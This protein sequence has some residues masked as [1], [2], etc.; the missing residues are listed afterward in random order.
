MLG[1]AIAYADPERA[2]VLHQE[3]PRR[4]AD[5]EPVDDVESGPGTPETTPPVAI[6]HGRLVRLP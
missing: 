2:D 5:S 1:S 4:V 3:H 6:G